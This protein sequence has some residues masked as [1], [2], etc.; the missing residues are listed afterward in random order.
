MMEKKYKETYDLEIDKYITK[1]MDLTASSAFEQL[2][3]TDPSLKEE[4]DFRKGLVKALKW[5][6]QINIAHTKMMKDKATNP[7]VVASQSTAQTTST[8]IRR[9]GLSRLLAYAA[10]VSLLVLAGL[11]W[12]AN[13]NFSDQQLADSYASGIV[14]LD[15]SNLKGGDNTSTDPFEQGL[16]YLKQEEYAQAVSFFEKI[17]QQ[18]EAYTKARLYLAF[19]QY[20]TNTFA[21][22]IQNANIVIQESFDTI[23]KQKATWLIVQAHL[24]QGKK[25]AD[26]IQLLK[27]IA[28]NPTH[29][30]QK[31]AK[32][33]QADLNNTWQKLVF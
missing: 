2:M 25:D 21:A 6:R 29:I 1:K 23:D 7:L 4:V 5:K 20:H 16:Y 8:P 26:F 10:S 31:D 3:A 13:T 33:L 11:S 12:F 9:I 27:S 18:N 15:D 32:K 24:K 17:P 14:S 19:S 22:A 30:H 28:D